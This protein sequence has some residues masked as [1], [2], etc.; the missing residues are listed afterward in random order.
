MKCR[1]MV[2]QAGKPDKSVL[3]ES[4]KKK[5]DLLLLQL[6]ASATAATL[7]S[8]GNNA[9]AAPTLL[10]PAGDWALPRLRNGLPLS[11]PAGYHTKFGQK[12]IPVK[13]DVNWR[14]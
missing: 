12:S 1:I 4:E 10:S 9:A 8:Y 6:D 5:G 13:A 11:V 2:H 3:L 14:N 7:C